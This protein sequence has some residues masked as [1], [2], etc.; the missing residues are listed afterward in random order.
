MERRSRRRNPVYCFVCCGVFL[1]LGAGLLVLSFF[2]D[3]SF[4]AM[5]IIIVA[6]VAFIASPLM[7]VQ[8]LYFVAKNKEGQAK[9]KDPKY[10][11]ART[12]G[13]LGDY[14]H[15]HVIL[16]REGQSGGNVAKNVAGAASF[17]FLG[18][19]V[20]SSGVNSI[21]CFV[22]KDEIVLNNLEKN[23]DFLDERFTR[24]PAN[25]IENIS[26]EQSKKYLRVFIRMQNQKKFVFDIILSNNNTDPIKEIFLSAAQKIQ[27]SAPV[28]ETPSPLE[29]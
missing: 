4:G 15:F 11:G 22:S 23:P 6:V 10:L 8:G 19:G 3:D 9:L 27:P 1:V 29:I 26:F 18:V 25:E 24:F 2:V 7:I 13:G 12:Y 20:F 14:Q 17:L 16:D 21:D 5:M 28:F